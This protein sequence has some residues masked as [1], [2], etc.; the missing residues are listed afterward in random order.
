MK[1]FCTI[2]TAASIICTVQSIDVLALLNKGLKQVQQEYNNIFTDPCLTPINEVNYYEAWADF[3]LQVEFDE[4]QTLDTKQLMTQF[5]QSQVS[6]NEAAVKKFGK[7]L[8]KLL[9]KYI[10]VKSKKPRNFQSKLSDAKLVDHLV[11][12]ILNHGLYPRDFIVHALE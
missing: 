6:K 11:D 1:L 7:K 10:M 5:W 12:M 4:L 3:L 8:A 9:D 2:I